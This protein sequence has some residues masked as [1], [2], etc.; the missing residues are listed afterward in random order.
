M[1]LPAAHPRRNRRNSSSRSYQAVP[2]RAAWLVLPKT[3]QP[4]TAVLLFDAQDTSPAPRLL[5]G[6]FPCLH[7]PGYP[8]G[9]GSA[10]MRRT[11]AYL[12]SLSVSRRPPVHFLSDCLIYHPDPLK[13]AE[14]LKVFGEIAVTRYPVQH[15]CPVLRQFFVTNRCL[16]TSPVL[17]Q[18]FCITV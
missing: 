13:P 14:V 3:S 8:V 11:M 7:S 2:P 18:L 9:T 1:R 12:T 10:A 17:P 15:R 16:P 5:L 6:R 4:G